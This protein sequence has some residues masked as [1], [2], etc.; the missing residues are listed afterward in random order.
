MPYARIG[1]RARTGLK[2]WRGERCDHRPSDPGDFGA[3][4]YYSTSRARARSY[5]G[6]AG[7]RQHVIQFDNPFVITVS[8]AYDLAEQYGTIHGTLEQRLA[9]ARKL[10]SDLKS[11][12]YDGLIAVNQRR[13]RNTVTELEIVRFD[14]R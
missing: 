8:A 3:G 5:G 12:G 10:T 6:L 4:K 13:R 7:T 2:V 11:Q 1:E 9:A 14:D